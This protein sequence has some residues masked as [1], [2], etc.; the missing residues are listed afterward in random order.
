MGYLLLLVSAVAVNDGR[1][2]DVLA[3]RV[4]GTLSFVIDGAAAGS[5]AASA[6]PLGQMP[7]LTIGSDPCLSPLVGTVTNLCI[8][9]P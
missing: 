2:H 5:T 7:P 4:G 8:T 9:S 3:Q 6:T 1:A